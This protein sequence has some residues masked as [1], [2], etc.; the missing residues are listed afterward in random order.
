MESVES[1]TVHMQPPRDHVVAALCALER[2]R[3]SSDNSTACSKHDSID[4]PMVKA[5]SAQ[6]VKH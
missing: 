5:L 2:M 4:A 6:H 1:K 3:C